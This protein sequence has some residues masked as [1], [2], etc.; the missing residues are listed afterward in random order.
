MFNVK[1]Y[2]NVSLS[3]PTN[4]KSTVSL[5]LLLSH[6]RLSSFIRRLNVSVIDLK[7]VPKSLYCS[8]EY[9]ADDDTVIIS[10]SFSFFRKSSR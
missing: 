5:P 2:I 6:V 9:S 8:K 10:V 4:K 7:A 3:V 1:A